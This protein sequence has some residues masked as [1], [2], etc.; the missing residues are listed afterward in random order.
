MHAESRLVTQCWRTVPLNR[1]CLPW[2]K[3]AF[4][5]EVQSS[6]LHHARQTGNK[7]HRKSLGDHSLNKRK[8][9]FG[10]MKQQDFVQLR[11]QV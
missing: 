6:W 5:D 7:W 1:P 8:A 2:V 11:L 10:A 9:Y 4:C 3:A